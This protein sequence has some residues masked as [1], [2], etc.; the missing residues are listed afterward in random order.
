M[1]SSNINRLCKK[2]FHQTLCKSVGKYV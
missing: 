2:I 1:T